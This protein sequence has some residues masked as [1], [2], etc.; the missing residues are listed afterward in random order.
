MKKPAIVLLFLL[1]LIPAAAENRLLCGGELAN[2]PVFLV[3]SGNDVMLL[4]LKSN[5]LFRE[6]D[7]LAADISDGS[8]VLFLHRG[9]ILWLDEKLNPH[10]LELSS[11]LPFLTLIKRPLHLSLVKPGLLLVPESHPFILNFQT[12]KK[13]F[14]PGALE[15]NAGNVDFVGMSGVWIR[16]QWLI[17]RNGTRLAVLDKSGMKEVM[18]FPLRHSGVADVWMEGKTVRIRLQNGAGYKVEPDTKTVT[19]VPR[20]RK[21]ESLLRRRFRFPGDKEDSIVE[22]RLEDEG[23]LSLL[24][25]WKKGRMKAFISIRLPGKPAT[26]HSLSFSIKTLGKFSF[27][28]RSDSG[29]L[30]LDFYEKDIVVTKEAGK[31]HFFTIPEQQP[32][33]VAGAA[34]YFWDSLSGTA[35][36]CRFK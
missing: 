9:R 30:V 24:S 14:F 22:L 5:V 35:K 23:A 13:C 28:L 27:S 17:C 29:A 21:D 25:A 7:V 12:K 1:T 15:W 3:A 20:N 6:N 36:S 16:G 32:Y 18:S 33:A 10:R 4:D 19:A 11:L 2:Q 34:V 8:G 31:I 26:E